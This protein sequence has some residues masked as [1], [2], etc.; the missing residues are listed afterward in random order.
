[1]SFLHYLI[2]TQI[3]RVM[4]KYAIVFVLA[5]STGVVFSCKSASEK[6]AEEII[7]KSI[8]STDGKQANVEIDKSGQEVTIETEEGKVVINA[9]ENKWPDDIP[10]DIPR[11]GN[12]KIQGVTTSNNPD[13]NAWTVIYEGQGEL[14]DYESKL[15]AGGFKVVTMTMGAA[16]SVSGE[17]DNKNVSL[18]VGEDQSVLTVLVRSK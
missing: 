15:K 8:E 5:F 16:G 9:K 7:E 3:I 11:P 10:S 13:G 2:W 1:M 17:K 14:K 6:A 18:M 12:L 4:K